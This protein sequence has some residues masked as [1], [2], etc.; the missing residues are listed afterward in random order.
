MIIGANFGI[1]QAVVSISDAGV[2]D[3][4]RKLV[5]P[6]NAELKE[7]KYALNIVEYYNYSLTSMKGFNSLYSAAEQN[8]NTEYVNQR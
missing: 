8:V 5:L 4:I 6:T 2:D 3:S 7:C 1:Y